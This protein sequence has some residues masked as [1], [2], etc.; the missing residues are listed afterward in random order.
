MLATYI[1]ETFLLE[2]A[3]EVQER[4]QGFF[5]EELELVV[6]LVLNRIY[7]VS[8]EIL[9]LWSLF[10]HEFYVLDSFHWLILI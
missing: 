1:I 7:L 4:I 9:Y 10:L 3:L 2:A 5:P 6:E 8:I